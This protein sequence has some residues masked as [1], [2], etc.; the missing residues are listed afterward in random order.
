MILFFLLGCSDS[1]DIP[2]NPGSPIVVVE[3]WLTDKEEVQYLR[4]S[5]TVDFTSGKDPAQIDDARVRVHNE[6]TNT[7][8]PY[9]NQ[10]ADLYASTEIFQA[11]AGNTYYVEIVLATGERIISEPEE[12]ANVP[13]I[14]S[15]DFESFTRESEDDP[16]VEETVYYPVA[17]SSDPVG[18][19]NFYRWRLSKNDTIFSDPEFIFLF[20]D[21]FIDADGENYPQEFLNYEYQLDDEARVEIMEIS[22]NAFEFLRQLK[23]QTASLTLNTAIAPAPIKG[24]LRYESSEKVVLGFF[25]TTSIH[26]MTARV[27]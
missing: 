7:Y 12:M 16:Q 8:E 3:G 6:S 13:P 18:E 9:E 27:E 5:S 4:L 2:V 23:S 24:N 1:L 10:G 19:D 14:E 25:G 21:R 26:S 17:Y 11:E 20:S 22:K 15:L